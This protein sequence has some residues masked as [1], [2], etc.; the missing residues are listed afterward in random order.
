MTS[1]GISLGTPHHHHHLIDSTN[2]RARELAEDGAASGT[3]VTA[4]EHRPRRG[5]RAWTAPP[6]RRSSNGDPSPLDLGHCCCRSPR[7]RRLRGMRGGRD[8]ECGSRAHHVWSRSA[9][10]RGAVEASRRVGGDRV[11]VNVEIGAGDF[12]GSA[13]AASRPGMGEVDL[14]RGANEASGAGW[15]R[16]P[17]RARRLPAAGGPAGRRSAGRESEPATLRNGR[18]RRRSRQ[19]A[20]RDGPASCTRW[21]RIVSLDGM[22]R[23]A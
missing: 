10:R 8:V 9:A 16:R 4:A 5:D 21:E 3:V 22:N 23:P 19:P 2:S 6:D 18:G 15:R 1:A 12:P 20:F 14:A 7:R 17:R 11:G 13:L